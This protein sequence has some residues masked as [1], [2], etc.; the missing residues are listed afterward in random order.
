[1]HPDL[2]NLINM[3]LADGELTDKKRE[4]ILRKAMALGEDKD[5]VE[6]ILE[7]KLYEKNKA[8]LASVAAPKSEKF[9]EVKKCPSCG[10]IIVAFSSKCNECDYEFSNISA[11]KSVK[12]L[13][14]KLEKVRTNIQ[15][16]PYKNSLTKTFEANQREE[17]ISKHQSEIINNF[18][19]PNSREDILDL[20]HFI[21]P[22]TKVGFG[23]DGSGLAWRSKFSEIID[24]AK[25]AYK[26]DN[27]MLAELREYE[28][29]NKTTLISKVFF[30]PK[31]TLSV[32][33]SIIFIT[34]IMIFVFI[35][36]QSKSSD[37]KKENE[38]LELIVKN[39]NTAIEEK[40]YDKAALISSQLKWEGDDGN[41]K[42]K[43]KLW[44]E[45]RESILNEIEKLKNKQ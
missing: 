10:A 34:V 14:D 9:G 12:D 38:R 8:K 25:L 7:A 23:S 39:I 22:K 36:A 29:Q 43:T 45:K 5:E 44:D 16:R 31:K 37:E 18:P 19:I 13:S 35:S 40:N 4:I 28:T 1:M 24:R 15:N 17:E 33:F 30:L 21:L 20:L 26:N 6:M 27:K 41:E 2:E 3:A 42:L 11:N 32:I